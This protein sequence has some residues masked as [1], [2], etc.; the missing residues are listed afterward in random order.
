MELPSPAP[1]FTDTPE[2]PTAAPTEV[3]KE[4]ETSAPTET[5]ITPTET[6]VILI[7]PVT[8]IPPGGDD[9]TVAPTDGEPDPQATATVTQVYVH[10]DPTSTSDMLLPATGSDVHPLTSAVVIMLLFVV[11]FGAGMALVTYALRMHK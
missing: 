8:A 5:Q 11:I 6:A 1:D 2:L 9:P 10:R 4:T 7:P 3:P